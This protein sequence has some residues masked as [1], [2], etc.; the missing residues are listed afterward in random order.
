MSVFTGLDTDDV[1]F[2]TSL[3][4]DGSDALNPDLGS[5]LLPAYVQLITDDGALDTGIF[6]YHRP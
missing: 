3:S 4:L 6:V 2:P 1:R 5:G